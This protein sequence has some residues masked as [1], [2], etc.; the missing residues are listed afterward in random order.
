[1]SFPGERVGATR[2]PFPSSPFGLMHAENVCTIHALG[3]DAMAYIVRKK[4]DG[5]A[6]DRWEIKDN[7]VTFGRGDEADIQ[8]KDERMSR[9]HFVVGP[10][11]DKFF[12]RDLNSTN[13][14]F[15]NN[16]RITEQELRPNDKIRAG[17]TVVVFE[18]EKSKGA[19]TV[20]NEMST[21]GKGYKTLLGEITKQAKH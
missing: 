16:N 18:L 2:F 20:I 6:L 3:D 14:T 21:E 15:V 12:V 1:M 9:Q 10:K 19:G 7:P 11:D 5:S 8:I 17:Q 13:G 4:L